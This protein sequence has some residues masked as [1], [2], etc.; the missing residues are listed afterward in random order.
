M[1]GRS[2]KA[3]PFLSIFAVNAIRYSTIEVREAAG[4]RLLP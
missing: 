1:E 4:G 3:P 2:S